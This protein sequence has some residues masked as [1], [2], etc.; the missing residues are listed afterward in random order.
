MKKTEEYL[1]LKTLAG[2]TCLSVRTLRDYIKS[3]ARPLPYYRL[4]G[5]H[6][7]Y[8]PDFKAWIAEYKVTGGIDIDGIVN[9]VLNDSV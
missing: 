3:P 5:K 1:D 4:A 8:W 9:D 6:L 2:R 7:V